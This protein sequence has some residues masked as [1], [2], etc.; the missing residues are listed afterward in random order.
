M[1]EDRKHVE[2]P[3]EQL[4]KRLDVRRALPSLAKISLLFAGLVLILFGFW[5]FFS[6]K[7][8]S[9]SSGPISHSHQMIASNCRACHQEPFARVQDA[10]CLNCHSLTPH[11][12]QFSPQNIAAHPSLQSSCADCHFEHRGPGGGLITRDPSM[13]TSCHANIKHALQDV[14]GPNVRSFNEHPQFAVLVAPA[15]PGGTTLKISLNDSK[16]LADNSH[17]KLNHHIHLARIR[18]PEGEVTLKCTSCHQL[19]ADFRSIKKIDFKTNCQS[20]HPLTY[21]ERFPD[22]EVPHGNANQVFAALFAEYARLFAFDRAAEAPLDDRRLKPGDP[23]PSVSQTKALGGFSQERVEQAARSAEKELYTRTACKLCHEVRESTVDPEEIAT[24]GLSRYEVI[25]PQIPEHWLPA[26]TFSHGA[27]EPLRCIECHAGAPDSKKTADVLIPKV[28]DCQK[29]H[30]Q[31][32]PGPHSPKPGAPLVH[33]DCILCHSYHEP[34][35]LA[36]VQKR[37]IDQVLS[38]VKVN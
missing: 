3:I 29:C 26:S 10:A 18:G 9:W 5:P 12:K 37:S 13:C 15:N 4:A 24:K 33:S 36:E 23:L 30:A 6:P 27:H 8:V 35:A 20:C 22:R 19:A 11:T 2:G 32:G 38:A 17:I 21:D 1:G 31:G 14:S 28:A 7:P 25:K 16:N 34:K